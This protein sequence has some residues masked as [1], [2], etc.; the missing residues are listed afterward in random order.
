[1][2]NWLVEGRAFL[3]IVWMH[4]RLV[5]FLWLGLVSGMAISATA[6]PVVVRSP[7]APPGI[8][9]NGIDVLPHLETRPLRGKRVGLVT[10]H[11]GMNRDRVPTLDL[12]WKDPEVNL[13]ALFS[14]EHG[15][16]GE[17]DEKVPDG[18]DGPTG[19]P[20]HSLY[21]VHRRPQP[22]QLKELD[23]L[24]FDIQDIGCRFYTYISTLLNVMEAASESG[25]EVVVLDRVN[26]IGAHRVGGPVQVTE[27]DFVACHSI[28][29]RHGMTVGEMA[30][31]FH[32]EKKLSCSLTI[33]AVAGWRRDQLHD[34]TGLPWRNPSPNMRN[35]TQALL[36]PGVGLVETTN[37]SVG[38]GTDEP[39]EKVG[40]PFIDGTRWAEALH[41]HGV[42]GVRFS[43]IVFV[44]ESSKHKGESCGGVQINLVDRE[45]L[46]PMELGLA[47]TLTLK[48][49]Y[50]EDFEWKKMQRLLRHEA[51]LER[52]GQPEPASRIRALWQQET[53]AFLQRRKAFLLYP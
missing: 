18:V 14:P 50:P 30:L 7:K 9:W 25:V 52:L 33:V 10:N 47:L 53:Q 8:V 49:L 23:V 41:R 21:G 31:L 29:I 13:K 45:L 19:L 38:R 46:D 42:A 37:L 5:S 22:E 35:L 4:F 28:S 17:L 16:R 36:Y 32:H 3:Q 44:P 26:P 15:I 12:L 43:P 51:T 1:M 27:P 2:G 20:V 48:D 40:A 24:V 11:T 6:A 34:E 39:F